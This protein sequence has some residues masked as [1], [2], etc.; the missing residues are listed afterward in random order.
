M[1][2]TSGST[3]FFLFF[4]HRRAAPFVLGGM[5]DF[6][7]RSTSTYKLCA[8]RSA[9]V[10]HAARIGARD[11]QGAATRAPIDE[12]Y[13]K[14]GE[15][16]AS[17]CPQGHFCALCLLT[18]NQ[19]RALLRPKGPKQAFYAA[20]S[21]G[22]CLKWRNSPAR[23]RPRRSS[24]RRPASATSSKL[25]TRKRSCRSARGRASLPTRRRL[26]SLPRAYG[27]GRRGTPD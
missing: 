15:S 1:V 17:G 5:A 26:I 9:P 24:R 18:A 6:A 12:G 2:R 22:V 10:N 8:V 20:N 21:S 14:T 13:P 16:H 19:R 27:G 3:V 11:H 7:A 25:Q 23:T 4:L